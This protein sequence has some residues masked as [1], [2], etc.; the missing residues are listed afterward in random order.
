MTTPHIAVLLHDFDSGGA[1]MRVA[2]IANHLARNG[3][4]VTVLAQAEGPAEDIRTALEPDIATVLLRPGLRGKKRR[5]GLGE[6]KQWL[7]SAEPDLI[8]AGSTLT[9]LIA[10][11]GAR[12][13]G[14]DRPP[15][16]LRASRHPDRHIP[17]RKLGK[18]LRD[19]WRRPLHRWL[20]DQAD[21]VIAVSEE[22]A[23]AIR[24]H[25]RRPERCLTIANP[26]LG[27]RFRAALGTAPAHPWLAGDVPVVVA[28]GRLAVSKDF[29]TLLRAF[30][31]ARAQRPMRLVILG[32]GTLR[33]DLERLAVELGIAADLAMPGHVRDAPA[34]LAA[35]SLSVSSSL[36][37]GSPAAIVEAL[38]AG[39][40]VV[41]TSCP[42]G[43]VE[44]LSDGRGGLLV[45]VR[46]PQAMARAILEALDRPWDRA[47]VRAVAAPYDEDES[48]RAYA[49]ALG[50]L[51]PM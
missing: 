3:W 28:L 22:T 20:Y 5:R 2:T 17:W 39:T 9:H 29:G 6:F 49:K 34:W 19:L 36:W 13:L 46:D 7:K 12:T 18:K 10:I 26:V 11:L 14:P 44:L 4:R 24:R 38:G 51:L 35:A 8:F 23:A 21:L 40:P 30:A 25:M 27:E 42:G 1:Q 32:E 33:P 48:C 31:M 43:S 37:E 47:A 50:G 16:V 45:P 15:V 41:A